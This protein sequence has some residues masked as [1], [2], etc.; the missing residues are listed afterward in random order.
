MSL[1]SIVV[2]TH[3]ERLNVQPLYER[4]EKVFENGLPYEFELIFCDD[5]T[6][7][8]PESIKGLAASDKRVRLVRLSRRFGQ[9]IAITA[10]LDY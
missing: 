7:D 10:G 8:T 5:S 3:N 1:I 9:A 2:P 6:D 4:L